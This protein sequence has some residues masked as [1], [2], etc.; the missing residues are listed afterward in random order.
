M[1]VFGG[2]RW[3]EGRPW[4]LTPYR[5]TK[6]IPELC[7]RTIAETD[8]G[9][10]HGKRISSQHGH[11]DFKPGLTSVRHADLN[12][13]IGFEHEGARY[14]WCGEIYREV[15]ENRQKHSTTTPHAQTLSDE[16]WIHLIVGSRRERLAS[17]SLDGT[18]RLLTI[19]PLLDLEPRERAAGCIG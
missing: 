15:Q 11:R 17:P 8:R 5:A 14:F 16:S 10:R 4:E 3:I 12:R 1:R 9:L 2:R 19:A 13:I 6:N 7:H 18:S